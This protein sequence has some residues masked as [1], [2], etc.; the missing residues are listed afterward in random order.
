MT[1]I[2]SNLRN[3]CAMRLTCYA[4]ISTKQKISKINRQVI[5]FGYFIKIVKLSKLQTTKVGLWH[6]I[7]SNPRLTHCESRNRIAVNCFLKY[8]RMIRITNVHSSMYLSCLHCETDNR[9]NHIIF[10]IKNVQ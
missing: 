8:Q 10:I 4:K 7:E 3:V 5:D 2:N 1:R 6:I 9:A